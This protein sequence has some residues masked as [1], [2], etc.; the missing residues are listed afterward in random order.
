MSNPLQ[1]MEKPDVIF[2][3]GTNM[4]EAHPVAATRLKKAIARGAKMI[5]ADPRVTRLAKIADLHLQIRVGSDVA[6]LLA[7][8]HVISRE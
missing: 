4:T 5:V 8:A 7:M 2:C 1:D 6:L 3:I